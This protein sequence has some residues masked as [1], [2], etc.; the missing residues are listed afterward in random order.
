MR[1]PPS[2][3]GIPAATWTWKAVAEWSATHA[4]RRLSRSSCLRYL[5]RLGFVWKRPI[6]RLLKANAAARDAFVAEYAGLEQAADAVDARIW[7]VDEACI[8][9]DADLHGL[10]TPKGEAA[11]VASTSPRKAEKVIYYSAVCPATGA[12][13]VAEIETTSCAVTTADFLRQLRARHAEPLI[14]IWDNSPVHG[15]EAVRSDLTTPDLR[16]QF[17][18]LPAYSPDFTAD[19]A[20]WKWLRTEVTANTCYGTK[21]ALQAATDAFFAGLA[22]RAD[23][24]RRR[25]RTRLD[26]A[27]DQ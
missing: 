10:W 27:A 19:E 7:F 17:V 9:A 4:H 16:L 6:T 21:R 26:R 5:H 15:G 8:R 14:V 20:I 23:E 3:V 13:E 11:L 12:V 18:R 2:A 25:C 22:D 1:Q 24:V